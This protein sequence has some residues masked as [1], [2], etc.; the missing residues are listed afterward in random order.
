ML[1]GLFLVSICIVASENKGLL[2]V[3][4]DGFE[5]GDWRNFRPHYVGDSDEWIRPN[6][7][8]NNTDPLTGDYSLQWRSDDK[9]HQW[10]MLSNAF[11][12]AK[13]VTVSVDF[14]VT[15]E[16][17]DFAAGLLLMETL[18]EYAGIKV[19][20]KGSDLF[21]RGKA[22]VAQPA[23]EMDVLPGS[24]Y[25][26]SVTLSD[27]YRLE[28]EITDKSSGRVV[29]SFETT[30]FIDPAAVSMYVRTGG[31]AAT[32]IDF[33]DLKVDG[34]DYLIPAG[35][36]VRSPYFVVLPRKP[37]VEQDQGNWVGGQSTMIKDGEFLMWYRIRDNK[38][39][40][41]GYGFARSN[42]GLDWVKYEN[43]PLFTHG[44]E[45]S[46]NEKIS[47]LHVDGLYRAWYAVDTPRG[48]FTAY[49]TSEDGRYW[50]QHGLAIDETYCKD[51]A[52]IYLDGTY[53]LYSIK[54]NDKIGIYTSPNGVDF[55]HR[56]TID[57][58]IHRHVAAFYEKRTGLFHLYSTGGHNG[59]CHAVSENG[60]DFGF[61]INV[62]N[63]PAVGIDDWERAGIT[64]LS[65]LTDNHG[66]IDDASSLPVYYQARNTWDNNIPGWLY[67]GGERVV[68]AGKFEGI[69]PGVATRIMPDGTSY[70]E[71][72]PFMVRRAGGL[73]FSAMRPV[74]VVMDQWDRYGGIT[75]SGSLE[76]LS[77]DPGNTQVQV[78]A[79][80][81]VPGAGYRLMIDG[82][83]VS[84]TVADKYGKL[85]FTFTIEQ[86]LP[87]ELTILS[88]EG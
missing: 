88:D 21:Q 52:V 58:G 55:T 20:G 28:A 50:E 49:A 30:S 9:S 14:R 36:Y 34:S 85:L 57:I 38:E 5:T 37:D 2:P 35:K 68:L 45:F 70:Y 3:N 10:L 64:Y 69:Y 8:I 31:G 32:T 82:H 59:V 23:I 27:D 11:Y 74:R 15:G 13:P 84:E 33:D 1:L 22:S 78:K 46:S 24:I 71:S 66:H 54:D 16:A 86:G 67:H 40:G 6:F 87:V 65:F 47:V 12:L 26:M 43:N 41:K 17:K 48:W 76:A 42:D 63:P 51:A 60:I 79:E 19:T 39:R 80:K 18:D 56:N 61:F 77:E 44:P 81:L 29:S 83:A 53:Y 7:V 4:R 25:R 72:F 75:A 62:W 73:S